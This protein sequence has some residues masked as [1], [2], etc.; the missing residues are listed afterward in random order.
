MTQD[1]YKVSILYYWEE[2]IPDKYK[3]LQKAGKLEKEAEKLAETIYREQMRLVESLVAKNGGQA[4]SI[5][6][7]MILNN[8]LP[9]RF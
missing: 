1:E 8:Y 5:A 9:N 7:E 6:E 3:R 2:E 4:E